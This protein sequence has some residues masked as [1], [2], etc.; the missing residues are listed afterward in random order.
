MGGALELSWM[1]KLGAMFADG[2]KGGVEEEEEADVE[3][4][5]GKVTYARFMKC[6]E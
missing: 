3:T 4:L 1:A 2:V 5:G 6:L